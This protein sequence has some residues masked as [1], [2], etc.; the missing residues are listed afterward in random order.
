M[1]QRWVWNLSD[2]LSSFPLRAVNKSMRDGQFPTGLKA[3]RI[4]AIHKGG[5]KLDPGNY[6]RPIAVL[7][8][9]SYIYQ[10]H[11]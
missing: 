3:A 4:V 5:I 7:L 10:R 6:I 1:M 11:F 2:D 9:L 8:N